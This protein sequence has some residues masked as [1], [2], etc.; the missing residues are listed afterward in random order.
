MEGWNTDI[1]ALE[2]PQKLTWTE[3][4]CHDR[5]CPSSRLG[6]G[7]RHHGWMDGPQQ[8]VT[9]LGFLQ[10][11]YRIHDGWCQRG[12]LSHVLYTYSTW[13]RTV[14]VQMYQIVR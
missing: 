7:E 8:H 2:G 4:V 14:S 13:Y 9:S 10:Y 6:F 11:Q 3:S 5:V 12:C 1:G